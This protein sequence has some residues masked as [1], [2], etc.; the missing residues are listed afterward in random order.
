MPWITVDGERY[1]MPTPKDMTI[2]ELCQA[3][4]MGAEIPTTPRETMNPRWLKAV[5]VIAKQRNGEVVNMDAIGELTFGNLD[6]EDDAP[7]PPNRAARRAAAKATGNH[8]TAP[9]Q[10]GAQS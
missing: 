8:E 2:D 6:F 9:E 7:P 10:P 1:V 3:S 5:I 4:D